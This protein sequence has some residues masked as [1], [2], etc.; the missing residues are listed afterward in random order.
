MNNQDKIKA[1]VNKHYGSIRHETTYGLRRLLIDLPLER[2]GLDKSSDKYI[3]L[4]EQ[5]EIARD[6]L[7]SRCS[8][9][10]AVK[11]R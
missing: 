11:G 9:K 4:S 6:E 7:D 1:Y 5:I 2:Y 10:Y 8:R 3:L